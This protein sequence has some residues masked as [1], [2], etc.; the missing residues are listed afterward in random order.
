MQVRVD[1][2]WHHSAVLQLDHLRIRADV[3][4]H[5]LIVA[6][7]N[8]TAVADRDRLRDAPVLVDGDDLPA[9]QHQVGGL[10]ERGG[11][12][13]K[14]RRRVMTRRI[15]ELLVEPSS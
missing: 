7:R 14:A 8:E 2:A 13:E 6:D 12:E 5:H 3:R 10:G 4:A 15:G 9:A 1:Q 11:G